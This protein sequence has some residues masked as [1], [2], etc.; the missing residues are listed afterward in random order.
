MR[1]ITLA[2][3]GATFLMLHTA[4]A[5]N[6]QWPE[7][8]PTVS[9]NFNDVYPEFPEPTEILDDCPEVVGEI[10][11]GWFVFRW[12]PDRNPTITD[13]AIHNMLDRM[14]EDFAYFRDVMGWPPD[15]RAREGYKSAIYLYGSGLC[16]DNASNTDGGGWQSAIWHNG[17]SWPMVLASYIPV[18]SF[19]PQYY[20][21][22]QTGAMVH[23]GIHSVLADMPAVKQ[24]AW[25]HEGGNVW[26]QQT[27]DARRAGSFNSMGNLNASDLIAPFM[28]IECYSGWLVDGSFGGPSAEGVNRFEGGQQICTWRNLLGGHQYSSMFPTF[29]AQI[30]GDAAMPWIW[31]NCPDRVLEGLAGGIGEEQMRRVITE[32]RAKMSIVDA[33]EW[34]TACLRLLNNNFGRNIQAE[35]EPSWMQPPVWR[36]TPYVATTRNGDQ[37]IPEQ[38]TLPGWSGA[39][40]I[41][42]TVTGSTVTIDFQPI[43]RNMTCQIA[44]RSTSGEPIYSEYVSSGNCTIQ[45]D[46]PPADN[47]VI[48]VVTNTDY[49]YEGEQTRTAKFD[50]RINL[51]EGV[52]GAADVY[53]RWY[54]SANLKDL[55]THVLNVDV[56]GTGSV[57]PEVKGYLTGDVAKITAIP[58]DGAVFI[59]WSGDASGTENPLYITMD[60]DKEVTAMFSTIPDYNLST[61]VIGSG[62]VSPGTGTFRQGTNVTLTATANAGYT[63]S[64]WSGDASGTDNPLG[65]TM[66]ANKSVVA[67]FTA[68]PE[69]VLTY[70]LTM[71][72]RSDYTSSQ[73]QLDA[74]AIA[75]ALG[76]TTQQV[77]SQATYFAI[78]PD[79]AANY[80]STAYD[81]GHWFGQNG[82]TVAY[83]NSAYIYSE[84]NLNSFV[85]NIG[86]FP[87]RNDDGDFYTLKQALLYDDGDPVQVTL[88]FNVSIGQAQQDTDNDGT[89]DS[90][91]ACP[92]DPNKAV[93]A[94]ICGC[95]NSDVDVDNDGICDTEDNDLDNDGVVTGE[96]CDDND[97]NVGVATIWYADTDNDG[98][99]DASSTIT[100]CTQPQG[101]VAGSGDECPDDGAKTEPGLCGCGVADNTCVGDETFT[102]TVNMDPMS[103][104]TSTLVQLD[105]DAVASTF[106]MTEQELID[107]FGTTVTYAALEPNGTLN[108]NSTAIAPGHWYDQNGNTV[109]YGDDAHVYAELDINTMTVNIGQFPDR[110]AGGDSYTIRQALI[111]DGT[112]QATLVYIVNINEQTEPDTDNDGTPD[113]EDDCP[114]DPNKI[115]PGECGCGEPEGDCT[116]TGDECNDTPA[117]DISTAYSTPYTTVLYDGKLYQNKWYAYGAVPSAGDPWQ[118]IG[119][120]TA[121]PLDCSGQ[122]TWNSA[123]VYSTAGTE[124]VYEGDLYV[125][126]WYTQGQTPG[127]EEVWRYLG[128]CTAGSAK[129]ALTTSSVAFY[130]NPTEGQLYLSQEVDWIL[131]N[132]VGEQIAEGSGDYINLTDQKAGLYMIEVEGQFYK[133]IKR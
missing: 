65:I 120:C 128:P 95:G 55:T 34:T 80:N 114:N 63:F 59:G 123:V 77:S 109:G 22:F 15:K 127:E 43:G 88:V 119:F 12:G 124:V 87:D 62:K 3:L 110:A 116:V 113:S 21:E 105:G 13:E 103:D 35:W 125:N 86:Q 2:M 133:V 76:L 37:L 29:L 82:Q 61:S 60:S 68:I 5:Q 9:Y 52:S 112:V 25:F 42:L 131:F 111:Y 33:A 24:S 106:N 49:I 31:V 39:N 30:L 122:S 10:A 97:P 8:S 83:G 1:K 99:G 79:G 126:Q 85:A 72:P 90:Q 57:T 46:E 11:D 70:N 102:F 45:L 64:H 121:T 23:E 17:E 78:N 47:V 50:Y 130:P 93:S 108:P 40:F 48:A 67:N 81:P 84:L 58:E 100:A 101:Y 16:T 26:L 129:Y 69:T 32:Y 27:A 19:D 41:P 118:L 98:V 51:V 38:R 104:Y 56:Q 73:V 6:F 75:N 20:D 18:R 36:A 14:N 74:N 54:N 44:Y 71:P 117:F 66:D 96:D 89:P 115:V 107:A 28:P 92:N 53:T 4:L 132:T 7:Y 94:G 91:D